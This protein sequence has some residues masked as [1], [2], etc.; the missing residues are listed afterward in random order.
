MEWHKLIE[1]DSWKRHKNLSCQDVL[2]WRNYSMWD[3][4]NF[5]ESKIFSISLD[6]LLFKLW[7]CS[8]CYQAHFRLY[9]ALVVQQL[10]CSSTLTAVTITNVNLGRRV[11]QEGCALATKLMSS[12][13]KSIPQVEGIFGE[14]PSSWA[15]KKEDLLRE[16]VCSLSSLWIGIEG[17]VF[18]PQRCL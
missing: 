3:K 11:R 5:N 1:I 7:C 9:E 4:H 10:V 8:T 14:W 17:E 15:T 18:R 6:I 13:L 12:I 2:S 16:A